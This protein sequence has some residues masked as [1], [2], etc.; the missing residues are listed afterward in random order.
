[1]GLASGLVGG[2]VI[3]GAIS[4][5]GALIKGNNFWTGAPKALGR[6]AFSFKNQPKYTSNNTDYSISSGT[7]ST[8]QAGSVNGGNVERTIN[9]DTIF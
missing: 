4:G 5:A 6:S 1:M 7:N 8:G 9:P 3:G 2:A